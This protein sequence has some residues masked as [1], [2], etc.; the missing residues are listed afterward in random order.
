MFVCAHWGA[1]GEFAASRHG[2][3]TRSQA[4]DLGLSR[5]VIGRL[6]DSGHLA[7]PLPGVLVVV[8]APATWEQR[9]RVATLGSSAAGTAGFRSGAALNRLDGYPR[10]PV[11]VIVP[12]WRQA[13]VGSAQQHR[14]RVEACDIVD[15]DGITC[16]NIA[17]TLADLGSV[18]PAEKVRVAFE[19]AWRRGVSL[20]WLRS[21]AER[22]HRPGQR[23]T[24]VLLHLLDEADRAKRPTESALELRLEQCLMG[25]PG[26]VRQY[27]VFDETARFVARVDFAVP[28]VKLALEAHSRQFHFGKIAELHD[29]LREHDLTAQG[30]EVLYFADRH[31]KS[32]SAV[33]ARV[34][35][36]ISRRQRDLRTK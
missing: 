36:V 34:D 27:E 2:A 12:T 33:R 26:L 31:L 6:K 35:A 18:D 1:V 30:W 11:E 32:P 20:M 16:T 24:G 10:I 7:E 29:E 4:A 21:T 17:R 9:L 28:H 25:L 23:G 3:L 15:V 5:K 8:G 19:S 13:L 22:L 14:A